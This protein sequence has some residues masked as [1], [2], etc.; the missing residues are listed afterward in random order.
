MKSNLALYH[1]VQVCKKTD[2]NGKVNH[3][4]FVRKNETAKRS[5]AALKQNR[6]GCFF[7]KIFCVN[8]YLIS[9]SL[10]SKIKALLKCS[11]K[12]PKARKHKA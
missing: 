5:F 11:I 8:F 2:P 6:S 3:I 10:S 1:F 7:L 9:V 4:Y 12:D